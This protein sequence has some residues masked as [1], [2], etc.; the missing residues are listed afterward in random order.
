MALVSNFLNLPKDL[1]LQIV[2]YLDDLTKRD[3]RLINKHWSLYVTPNCLAAH[4]KSPNFTSLVTSQSSKIVKF[5]NSYATN[6]LVYVPKFQNIK[7]LEWYCNEDNLRDLNHILD[8]WL[9]LRVLDLK[10]WLMESLTSKLMVGEICSKISKLP[11]LKILKVT[12]Y[13]DLYLPIL[14]GLEFS[15]VKSLTIDIIPVYYS[16][17][18]LKISKLANLESLV[19]KL[20]FD[21]NQLEIINREDLPIPQQFQNLK[22]LKKLG[23]WISTCLSCIDQASRFSKA[24]IDSFNKVEF[25]KLKEFEWMMY[26]CSKDLIV[27]LND[28]LLSP[29]ISKKLTNLTKLSLSIIDSYLLTFLLE[30]CP[31]L[32]E[33]CFMSPLILPHSIATSSSPFE[34]KFNHLKRLFFATF[35]PQLAN[36]SQIIRNIFPK[37]TTLNLTGILCHSVEKA[38][39]INLVPLLFPQVKKLIL[40][41][42]MYKFELLNPNQDILWEELFIQ[43]GT[44]SNELNTL[45]QK[46]PKLRILYFSLPSQLDY[47][48]KLNKEGLIVYSCYPNNLFNFNI[49]IYKKVN[50]SKWEKF[51]TK[52]RLIEK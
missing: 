6:N 41:S 39:D 22:K 5:S 8:R 18:I 26:V 48:P 34:L 49:K 43:L 45:I 1:I 46:L 10:F 33:L 21:K 52:L 35:S 2:Q 23:I 30:S 51:K 16:K 11:D 47:K 29:I 19:F 3:L 37:V 36:N 38:I 14:D 24:L 40:S 12:F 9:T 15:G 50:Y 20:N 28:F 32:I 4:Q 27:Q 44:P 31:H 13:H 17:A 7:E 25:Q 42:P